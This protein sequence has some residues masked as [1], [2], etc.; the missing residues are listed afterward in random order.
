M[1]TLSSVL[2]TLMNFAV[3]RKT[4]RL[5]LTTIV[6]RCA[7][8]PATFPSSCQISSMSTTVLVA[9]ARSETAPIYITADAYSSN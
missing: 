7:E 8:T 9:W 3:V 2:R 4:L 1:I 6:H 5:D